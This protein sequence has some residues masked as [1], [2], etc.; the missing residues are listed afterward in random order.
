MINA[1]LLSWYLTD[2]GLFCSFSMSGVMGI[3]VDTEDVT[4]LAIRNT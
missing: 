4:I 3:S 2:G 1:F